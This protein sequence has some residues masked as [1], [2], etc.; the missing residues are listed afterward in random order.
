M[1]SVQSKPPIRVLLVDDH[2]VVREGLRLI[3]ENHPGFEI[4]GQASNGQLA[5][6]W[7]VRL[8]PDVVV[9]DIAMPELNGIEATRRIRTSCPQTQV[10]ILSM[11]ET[12][13]LMHQAMKAGALGYMLKGAGS[14]EL[15]LAIQTIHAGRRFLGSHIAETIAADSLDPASSPHGSSPLELLSTREQEVLQRVVEGQSSQQI[16]NQMHLSIKTVETYRSRLMHKLNIHDIPTLVKFAI[17]H[18]LTQ[19]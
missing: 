1:T 10:L 4:L 13:E 7:T 5:V 2:Q 6:E 3:L 19:P 11:H 8:H 12:S 16:A 9:M 17:K 18:G 14:E 15:V